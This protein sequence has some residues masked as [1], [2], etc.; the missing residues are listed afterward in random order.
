MFPGPTPGK[1]K[2]DQKHISSDFVPK[3]IKLPLSCVPHLGATW[4][5]MSFNMQCVNEL[6]ME[7]NRNDV[8]IEAMIDQVKKAVLQ[9]D[10]YLGCASN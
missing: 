7:G 5:K 4:P 6:F 9:F 8:K 2:V 10:E 3:G 1:K